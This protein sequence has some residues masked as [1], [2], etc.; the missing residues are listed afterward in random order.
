MEL[1]PLAYGDGRCL[2]LQLRKRYASEL[3][4]VIDHDL[5][6]MAYNRHNISQPF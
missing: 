3:D 2:G 5:C 4:L 1:I 6:Q